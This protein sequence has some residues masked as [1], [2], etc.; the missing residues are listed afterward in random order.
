M[1]ATVN[2]VDGRLVEGSGKTPN[3]TRTFSAPQEILEELAAHLARTGRTKPEELV[4]QAPGGGPVRATNFRYRRTTADIY[5]PLPE[6]V[7][8]AAAEQ[9]DQLFK[10]SRAEPKDPARDDPGRPA[11]PA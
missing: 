8:R 4:L 11:P 7:D 6:K 3:S 9:L 1:E 5:G 10:A 2:E